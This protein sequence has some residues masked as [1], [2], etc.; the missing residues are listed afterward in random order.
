MVVG[1]C[2]ITLALPGND[3]LKGKRS[4]V[5]PILDRVRA[6]FNVA[7]AE[8]D[9]MDVLRTATLG[10]AVVSNQRSHAQSMIDT[11]SSFVEQQGRGLVTSRSVEIISIGTFGDE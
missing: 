11:V 4:V 9:T 5:R 2:R 10:F 7:A 8:V 3:S 6:K 1:A